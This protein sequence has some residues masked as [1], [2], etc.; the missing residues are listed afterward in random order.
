M[1]VLTGESTVH[2]L[3]QITCKLVKS[4]TRSEFHQI[5]DF[6]LVVNE[7]LEFIHISF[8]GNEI[9]VCCGLAPTPS[10]FDLPQRFVSNLSAS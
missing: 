6:S 4:F 7:N 1:F 10:M 3:V 2:Q 5:V 9:E 8:D